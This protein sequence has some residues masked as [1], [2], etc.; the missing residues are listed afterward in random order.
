MGSTLF[1]CKHKSRLI[2]KFIEYAISHRVRYLNVQFRSDHKPFKLSNFNSNSIQE[3]E[4]EIKPNDSMSESDLW[5]LPVLSTL[6]LTSYF[7]YG[8]D[9][10]KLSELYLTCLPALRNLLL[11]SWDLRSFAFSLP[12]LTTLVLCKCELPTNVWNLPALKSLT[13]NDVQFPENMKDLFT[14]LVNL[15]SLK[16]FYNRASIQ[17]CSIHCPELVNLEIETR[18]KGYRGIPDST[19]VVFAPELR[20]FTSVGI[21]AI[22]FEDSKFDHVNVKLRGWIDD[23]NFSREKLKECYQQFTVMLPKLGSAK[24]LSFDLETIEVSK[25]SFW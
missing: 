16:S 2:A 14:A 1:S 4:L 12:E 22:T 25:F 13:L 6:R 3:L 11:E 8:F 24:I 17:Y 21:F 18:Y 7:Y 5:D 15:R 9:A 20:N 19:V 10:D 23:K